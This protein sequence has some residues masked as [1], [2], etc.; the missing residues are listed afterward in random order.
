MAKY[1]KPNKIEKL[2]GKASRDIKKAKKAVDTAKSPHSAIL[3]ALLDAG[4][5][6]DKKKLRGPIRNRYQVK[7]GSHWVK[8]D[9]KGNKISIKQT[10]G[11]YKRIRKKKRGKS[12]RK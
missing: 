6:A 9:N 8:Y 5:K 10:S 7:E 12:G 4:S 2:I 3:D 11:P 1:K